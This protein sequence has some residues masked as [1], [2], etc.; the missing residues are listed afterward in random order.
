MDQ[1]VTLAIASLLVAGVGLGLLISPGNSPVDGDKASVNE[2]RS[3]SLVDVNSGSSFRISGLE[4]PVLVGT[5]AVWCTRCEKRQ[6]RINKLQRTYGNFSA[7][8]LDV[9]PAESRSQVTRHTLSNQFDWRF[10]MAQEDIIRK[11]ESKFGEGFPKA[12]NNSIAV[13]CEDSMRM[14]SGAVQKDSYLEEEIKRGC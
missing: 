6:E 5:F 12:S 7:I 1:K 2:I 11:L 3:E 13:I 4:K 14:V 9:D 8:S 10:V